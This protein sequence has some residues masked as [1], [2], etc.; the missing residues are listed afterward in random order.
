MKTLAQKLDAALKNF[1][2]LEA[3]SIEL[4][5][6]KDEDLRQLLNATEDPKFKKRA[7]SVNSAVFGGVE[8]LHALLKAATLEAKRLADIADLDAEFPEVAEPL[9]TPEVAPV[10]EAAPV[11]P[12]PE[13][14]TVVNLQIEGPEGVEMVQENG[15]IYVILPDNAILKMTEASTTEREAILAKRSPKA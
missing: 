1:S 8:Y 6:I 5:G 13:E 4:D 14:E 7:Q 15:Q 11:A 9:P 3:M 12:V 2:A 10:P